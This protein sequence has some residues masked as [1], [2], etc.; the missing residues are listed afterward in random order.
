MIFLFLMLN[1][2]HYN[3]FEIVLIFYRVYSSILTRI[4]SSFSIL[5]IYFL[6]FFKRYIS[7]KIFLVY[8]VIFI[9]IIRLS[10]DFIMFITTESSISKSFFSI[11]IF[12]RFCIF[13]VIIVY[14]FCHTKF[15]CFLISFIILYIF[16]YFC[17]LL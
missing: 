2:V 16:V 3:R 13:I 11:N 12:K 5:I 15:L 6:C 4:V 8:F 1:F 14:I 17:I 9:S 10:I 7:N